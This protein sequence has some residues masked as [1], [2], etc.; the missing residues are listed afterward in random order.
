M[1]VGD[2]VSAYS[3]VGIIM[4]YHPRWDNTSSGYPWYVWMTLKNKINYFQ[5]KDLEVI[6]EG[7]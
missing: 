5:T 4:E 2:L 3:G 6:G 1:K 7:G